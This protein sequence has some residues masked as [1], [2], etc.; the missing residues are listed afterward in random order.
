MRPFTNR[1]LLKIIVDKVDVG[2]KLKYYLFEIL[3]P[4]AT[5]LIAEY[6]CPYCGRRFKRRS[7]LKKHLLHN[8]KCSGAFKHDWLKAEELYRR[9][10]YCIRQ[11]KK[12][13]S[14][15]R[16]LEYCMEALTRENPNQV[17]EKVNIG[18]C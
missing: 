15:I 11:Q 7:S 3:N 12:K 9:M 8:Q 4:Q 1:E 16:L 18:V 2:C 14:G 6:T 5:I 17:R 13:Y 10:Y